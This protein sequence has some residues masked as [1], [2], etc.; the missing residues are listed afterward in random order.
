[1]TR[2]KGWDARDARFQAHRALLNESDDGGPV[3]YRWEC[4]CRRDGRWT[5]DKV[6]AEKGAAAHELRFAPKPKGPK[7]LRELLTFG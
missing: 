7:V 5:T 2:A 6:A 4:T 3:I 1:M